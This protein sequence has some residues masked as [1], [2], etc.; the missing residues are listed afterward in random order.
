MRRRAFVRAVAVV[1]FVPA[2]AGCGGGKADP[3]PQVEEYSTAEGFWE[4]EGSEVHVTVH[5]D[6]LN[7]S[8]QVFVDF[9]DAEGTRLDR[10]DRF[11][12]ML[13]D[14]TRV[15]TVEVEIPDGADRIEVGARF[16][17]EGIVPPPAE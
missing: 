4:S 15:V 11:I 9:F 6:G 1:G 13:E 5:N 10:Q 16:A 8:V 12:Q 14:E 7:G 17:E 3:D 2:M